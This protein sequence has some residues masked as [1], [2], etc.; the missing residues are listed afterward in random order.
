MDEK[1][2]TK[3]HTIRGH[4]KSLRKDE[5]IVGFASA[6]IGL[7]DAEN[8]L[9][10]VLEQYQ[11][12]RDLTAEILE[13]SSLKDNHQSRLNDIAASIIEFTEQHFKDTTFRGVRAANVRHNMPGG[14][15]DRRAAMRAHWASGK[16]TSRD[17]CAEQECAALEMSF[18]AAR[19]ALRN[20]PEPA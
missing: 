9:L 17:I 3:Y 13:R 19:K 12:L 6:L 4:L 2:K 15:R 1:V 20:M 18:S 5:L 10:K 8:R 11:S 7:D 16:Y 14:S